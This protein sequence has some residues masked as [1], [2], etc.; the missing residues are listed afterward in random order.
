MVSR[1]LKHG[2]N[3]EIA[4]RWSLTGPNGLQNNDV[5]Y[6]SEW[7]AGTQTFPDIAWKNGLLSIVWQDNATNTIVFRQA[8]FGLA[9]NHQDQIQLACHIGPNPATDF[10]R[11]TN[12]PEMAT[13][14][15]L[16]DAQGRLILK[17]SSMGSN[18]IRMNVA[19][20]PNGKYFLKPT[21]KDLQS[22]AQSILIV[23]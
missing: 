21:G 22:R 17:Q 9:L 20:L 8:V 15:Q 4:L 10:I 1:S 2:I 12:L 23:H 11:I 3:T 19:Q 7:A 14:I 16:L 5:V 18:E 6:V 13:E